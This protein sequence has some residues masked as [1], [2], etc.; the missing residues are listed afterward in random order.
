V[1][2][3]LTTH[4]RQTNRRKHRMPKY[5]VRYT[6]EMYYELE[7][8]ADSVDDARTYTENSMGDHNSY[9][10]HSE[11]ESIQEVAE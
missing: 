7:V 8:T 6:T 10:M 4:P 1:A 2:K 5:I 11:I 9:D 3:L